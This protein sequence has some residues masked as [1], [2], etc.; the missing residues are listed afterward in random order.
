MRWLAVEIQPLAE[1]C[2][3]RALPHPVR[4]GSWLLSCLE[5]NS[6]VRTA[7]PILATT[8]WSKSSRTANRYPCPKRASGLKQ[9]TTLAKNM[10]TLHEC[11][12]DGNARVVRQRLSSSASPMCPRGREG[13]PRE[14]KI[15]VLHSSRP[16]DYRNQRL[17]SNARAI[18]CNSRS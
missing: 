7:L 3:E 10:R 18:F 14:K 1:R 15:I 11:L 16:S 4:L 9:W 2:A 12:C 17:T 13:Q 5:F 8:R 6:E